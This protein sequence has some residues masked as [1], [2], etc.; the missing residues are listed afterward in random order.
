MNDDINSSLSQQDGLFD[1]AEPQL[2][3]SDWLM[4]QAEPEKDPVSLDNLKDD[5]IEKIMAAVKN[6]REIAKTYY[7]GTASLYRWISTT[8]WNG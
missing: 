6:G 1:R 8:R 7:E 4:Q 5:E 3:I 2:N